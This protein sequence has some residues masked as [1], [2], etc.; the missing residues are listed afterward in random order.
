MSILSQGSEADASPR[1]ADEA[2]GPF[3]QLIF[4]Q[5]SG[6]WRDGQMHVAAYWNSTL[7]AHGVLVPGT[8]VVLTEDH[9]RE[10]DVTVPLDPSLQPLLLRGFTTR[11][12]LNRSLSY[13]RARSVVRRLVSQASFVLLEHVSSVAFLAG[14]AAIATRTPFY[15]E[16]GGSMSPPPGV[17]VRRPWRTRLARV[18]FRRVE[19]RLAAH[20]KL[21]IAVSP[22]LHETFPQSNAPKVVS[23]HSLVNEEDIFVRDDSCAGREITLFVATRIIESK[24]IDDLI[25]ALRRLRDEGRSVTLKIAGEGDY[26]PQ[27]KK[28]AGELRLEPHVTFLGGIPAGRQLWSHYRAADIVVLPSRG[29]YE[30]TPRMIIEAWAAGAPVIAT[31]VGGIPAMVNQEADGLL[32]P[33][34]DIEALTTAIKRVIDDTDLRRRLIIGGYA[35]ARTMT[36][37]GRLRLLRRAFEQHL[38]GLLPESG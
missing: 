15:L 19:R 24:G 20:A 9:S 29:H 11:N 17:V 4:T 25:K 5:T 33:H 34:A 7:R 36:F 23:Y 12:L 1:Y 10:S 35:R 26:L 14:V 3:H 31:D 22:H 16:M 6:F 37:E 13:L 21:L 38:P 2:T 18:Y 30:G 27:L 28:L 32:V 8:T